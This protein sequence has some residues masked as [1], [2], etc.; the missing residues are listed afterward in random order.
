MLK[1][2]FKVANWRSYDKHYYHVPCGNT[3]SH[4]IDR[5][6]LFLSLSLICAFV[7]FSITFAFISQSFVHFHHLLFLTNMLGMF[8][9][10]FLFFSIFFFE[11]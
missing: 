2:Y 4:K 8:G 11:I 7:N 10:F 3:D 9:V 1:E 5:A 6:T